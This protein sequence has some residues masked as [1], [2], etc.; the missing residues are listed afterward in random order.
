MVKAPSRAK[1]QH[2]YARHEEERRQGSVLRLTVVFG[3]QDDIL[4]TNL[5]HRVAV[6]TFQGEGSASIGLLHC[7]TIQL[8]C[9]SEN[10]DLL[11]CPQP[12]ELGSGRRSSPLRGDAVS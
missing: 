10:Q 6:K 11:I 12:E 8:W 4:F 5:S 2:H 3:R 7:G 9:P 1:C